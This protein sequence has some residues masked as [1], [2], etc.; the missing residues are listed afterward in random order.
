MNEL[1]H[2]LL[3]DGSHEVVDVHPARPVYAAA[4]LED[5]VRGKPHANLEAMRRAGERARSEFMHLRSP[6]GAVKIAL[7]HVPVFA[8]LVRV[9]TAKRADGAPDAG[10]TAVEVAEAAD[11]PVNTVRSIIRTLIRNQV[12]LAKTTYTGWQGMRALYYPTTVGAEA[13]A[14]AEV[15]GYG[16]MIQV[17]RG[18]AA[19]KARSSGEP[20]NLFQFFSLV[21]RS[22]DGE[23]AE[24]GEA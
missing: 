3:D 16:S 12:V 4:D 1:K 10:V 14:I 7:T 24:E 20:P 13:L 18:H 23:N 22:G 17:G 5:V 2:H 19:W 9:W 8:A 21:V 15:I 11:V 6:R